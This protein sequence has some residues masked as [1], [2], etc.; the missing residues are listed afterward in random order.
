M[1][2]KFLLGLIAAIA[3]LSVRPAHALEGVALVEALRHGG[4]NI[5]MRHA[6]APAMPPNRATADLDN[7]AL[8]RQLDQNG[9]DTARAMGTAL[10]KLN[11]PIGD[12][13][14]SPTY[15]ARET[16]LI[17]AGSTC[18][19]VQQLGDGGQSMQPELVTQWA[20]WLKDKIAERPEMGK[21]RLIVTHAPNIM[22]AFGDDAQGLADGEALVFQP[23]G[24][25]FRLVA[26]VKIQDWPRL[27]EQP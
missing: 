18:I 9:R 14:C 22:A 5:L 27:A 15:R 11:I 8:E 21:N 20:D 16:V 13:L 10:K 7:T 2:N 6:S 24:T 23:S 19:T 12:I 26:R 17:L 3:L 25:L 4:Y 1:A